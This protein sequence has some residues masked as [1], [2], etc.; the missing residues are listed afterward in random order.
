MAYDLS[1]I[2]VGTNNMVQTGMGSFVNLENLSSQ[3]YEQALNYQATKDGV[4]KGEPAILSSSAGR[5]AFDKNVAPKIQQANQNAQNVQNNQSNTTET[6]EVDTAS[7]LA[8]E[9]ETPE[10]KI[11]RQIFEN[12]D[13]QRESAENIFST[14][15]AL[16]SQNAQI[17]RNSLTN[18]YNQRRGELEKANER[19]M[20]DAQTSM[21]RSGVARYAPQAA[22]NFLSNKEQEY[23]QTLTDL[24]GEYNSKLWE[25]NNAMESKS[26]A[27]AA[28]LTQ[29]LDQINEKVLKV[30]KEQAAEA[31]KVN[32]EL[33]ADNT[34]YDA[35]NSGYSTIDEIFEF[36]K[37]SLTS[38]EIKESLERFV[39]PEEDVKG[40][41]E[42]LTGDAKDYF[43]LKDIPGA[44]PSGVKDLFDYI[45]LKEAAGR[46]PKATTGSGLGV[47]SVPGIGKDTTDAINDALEGMKFANVDARKRADE[48]IRSK[49]LKNDVEGAKNLIMQYAK[50]SFGE[51]TSQVIIGYE[52][53]MKSL[54]KIE[55]GLQ[56]L[57]NA[58]ID[59]G[60]LTG[61]AQK[62]LER[63]GKAD[64]DLVTKNIANPALARVANDVML[65]IISFRRAVSGAA[66]T[67]SEGEAYEKVFPSIGKDKELNTAKIASLRENFK[68]GKDAYLSYRI[69]GYDE[70]FKTDQV[71]SDVI[72]VVP[73]DQQ[74]K[75]IYNK[76]PNLQ[77]I[78]NSMIQEN[79][80]WDEIL[81]VLT[82]ELE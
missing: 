64:Y 67:E 25:V 65:A 37:G 50:N 59:T 75:G 57:E 69:N 31:S 3:G 52:Q 5:N 21:I 44:L 10:D 68:T 4:K 70:L 11:N 66:F 33:V 46:E 12:Y 54:D 19:F 30:L 13:K 6:K 32:R 16:Q 60:L 49:L 77:P 42:K 18:S 43:I 51:T 2:N 35:I 22:N 24:D 8:S 56:Q 63:I 7:L 53:G 17:Q 39:P 76:N 29:E 38:K 80:S 58:G 72:P 47:S 55:S 1:K 45:K 79:F 61:I 36:S 78:V 48:A 34:V 40:F 82:A 26:I 20:R 9:N 15:T 81:Q 71:N 62:N 28:Q 74:V 14:L 73:A 27:N 23:I 41:E